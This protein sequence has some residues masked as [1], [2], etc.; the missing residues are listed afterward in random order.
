MAAK[1]RINIT[2]DRELLRLADREARRRKISRSA[3]IRETLREAAVNQQRNEEE[4]AVRE[5]RRKAIEGIRAI[6]RQM[7][8]WPAEQILHDWRY[9]LAEEGK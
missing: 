1:V 7:G 2:V 6:A 5:G 8:D 9:R 3:L 4:Q